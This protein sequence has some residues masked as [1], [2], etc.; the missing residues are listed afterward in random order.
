MKDFFPSLRYSCVLELFKKYVWDDGLAVMFA[1]FCTLYGHLPQGAVSSPHISNLLLGEVDISLRKFCLTHNLDF[2]RYADDLTFSGDPSNEEIT[3]LIRLCRSELKQKGLKLNE[4]KT[5]ILRKG[6][7]QEVTGLVVNSHLN[8]PREER[9][10]LRQQMYYLNKFWE[11]KH[12]SFDEHSLNVLLGK[13]NFIWDLNR[14]NSE[15]SE[16]RKQLLEIK[17]YF[18]L[19]RKSA[20]V[21]VAVPTES[22]A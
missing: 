21:D 22:F 5:R 11:Q 4:S 16:Y 6:M 10:F 1:K 12:Q 2:T 17:H 14:A 19:K 13:I 8:A 7:R 15:F 3:E 20:S 9:R 18:E